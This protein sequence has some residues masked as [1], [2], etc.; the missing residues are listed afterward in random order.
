[1]KD[2]AELVAEAQN[3]VRECC[4]DVVGDITEVK[5][6]YRAR[7]RWGRCTYH[8][9]T[10]KYSIEISS[11]I[12]ADEVPYTAVMSTVVHEVL[13]ACKGSKGHGT[14]WKHYASQVMRSYPELKITRCAS[15]EDFGLKEDLQ[16][17]VRKYAIRCEKCGMTHY[18]SRLSKSIKFPERYR[19]GRCSG[20]MKRIY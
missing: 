15:A 10:G 18:S 19:C 11:R 14:Q 7:S 9:M 12:L 1:M 5:V 3:I 8:G 20:I 6:N 4:G 17:V 2:C 16:P 13:H